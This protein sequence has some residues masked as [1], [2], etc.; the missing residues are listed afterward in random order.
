MSSTTNVEGLVKLA[1]GSVIKTVINI[2]DARE[3]GFSPFGGINIAVKTVGGVAI[4]KAAPAITKLIKNKP[5]FS[6]S[7]P[8]KEGWEI[9]EIAESTPAYAETKINTTKG[10]YIVKVTAIPNMAARNLNY[11]SQLNEPVYTVNWATLASWKPVNV[12]GK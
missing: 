10:E 12:R 5:I 2:I 4:Q 8:P 1:D 11:Q 6:E 9:V 7:K 3:S